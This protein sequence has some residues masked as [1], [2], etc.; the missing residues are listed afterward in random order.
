MRIQY[1]IALVVFLVPITLFS[2][3]NKTDSVRITGVVFEQD[4]LNTLP[5]SR[6][7]L[8]AKSFASD[9]KGQFSFWAQQGEVVRFSHMGFKDTYIQVD[10]SLKHK[11]YM[12]GVFLTRDTFL[13]SEVIVMPRY[14]NIALQA[15][16]MPLVITPEQA[17]A[18]NNIRSST[19]QA[20]TQTP[21]RMDAEMNHRMVLQ[22]R[23][24]STVYKTQI[25]P[26]KTI[27]VSSENMAQMRLF[28]PQ[29]EQRIQEITLQ[30]LNRNELDL[31]LRIYEQQQAKN[32]PV[33]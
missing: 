1:L 23:T 25:P 9:E 2:Q 22:E 30:P 4:S 6:F 26:G 33:E 11:N 29:N 13:I 27:G 12:L 20:L 21:I 24:W 8:D 14:E 19:H 32:V 10:D 15:K 5:Y 7:N 3:I 31:I 28:I 17:Y 18:T 16:T